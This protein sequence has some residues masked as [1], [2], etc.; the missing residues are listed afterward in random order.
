[1]IGRAIDYRVDVLPVDQVTKIVMCLTTL[2]VLSKLLRVV[3]VDSRLSGLH[4]TRIN[5]A[6]SDHLRIIVAK[7]LTQIPSS[8]VQPASN[9]T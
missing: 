1:M 9:Q 8:P 5:V 6:N 2:I 3:A 4:P 7:D